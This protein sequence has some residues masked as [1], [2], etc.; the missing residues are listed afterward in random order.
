MVAQ[1]ITLAGKEFVILSKADFDRL[2]KRAAVV[3]DVELPALPEESADGTYP[4]LQAGR[5]VL[6]RK[7]IRRRWAAGLT[8]AALA[9]LARV[10]PETLNRIE[11]AR[12]TADTATVTKV[13]RALDKAGRRADRYKA[14]RT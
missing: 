12:V 11:K 7:L 2:T 4:A 13:V 8:Q 3:E 1:N 5:A 9:R 6:A 10:R 14:N